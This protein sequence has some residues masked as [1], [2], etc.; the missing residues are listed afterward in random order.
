M[1]LSNLNIYIFSL[2]T[3]QR[4]SWLSVVIFTHAVIILVS[5]PFAV[6]H[7][8]HI[9][10]RQIHEQRLRGERAELKGHGGNIGVPPGGSSHGG[11]ALPV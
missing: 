6:L 9:F 7:T 10:S 5:T 4:K 3:I 11:V 8:Y 2:Q 1:G